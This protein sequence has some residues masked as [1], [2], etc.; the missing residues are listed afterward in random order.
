MEH[1][2]LGF[3]RYSLTKVKDLVRGGLP[4]AAT[5]FASCLYGVLLQLPLGCPSGAMG[6]ATMIIFIN[7][8]TLPIYCRIWIKFIWGKMSNMAVPAT[9]CEARCLYMC[10][11]EW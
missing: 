1:H 10:V 9:V 7:T 8:T 6:Q 4:A 5:K 2:T 11:Y 3:Q